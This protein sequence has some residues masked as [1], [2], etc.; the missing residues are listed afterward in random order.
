MDMFQYNEPATYYQAVSRTNILP[1]CL[2]SKSILQEMR[3]TK[4]QLA[5]SVQRESNDVATMKQR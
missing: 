1:Q 4:I 2:P 5:T 3:K